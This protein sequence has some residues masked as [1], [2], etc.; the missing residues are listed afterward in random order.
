MA[1]TKKT[2]T[3]DNSKVPRKASRTAKAK[4]GPA[5]EETV[6][7]EA[8]L[9][10][11]EDETVPW[12]ESEAKRLLRQDL[13]E[14]RVPDNW[15]GVQVKQ[16]RP[17][18]APYSQAR[19]TAN[20][21]TLRDGLERD[22]AR[23]VEDV[24]IFGHDMALLTEY[25][26]KNPPR[27]KDYPNFHDHPARTLLKSDIDDNK[28]I[29]MKPMKLR[30]SRPE[31]Q[32]FPPNVFR[33]HI[34]Q[35]VDERLSRAYR[36]AKKGVR[37]KFRDTAHTKQYLESLENPAPAETTTTAAATAADLFPAAEFFPNA[38]PKR[39]AKKKSNN[40]Q[41]QIPMRQSES[42]KYYLPQATGEGSFLEE[43]RKLRIESLMA[44]KNTTRKK[45]WRS[46]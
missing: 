32:E 14:G 26:K 34:Y 33:K 41:E 19:F 40:A 13:I 22:Y 3:K 18:Y 12:A 36:F 35:E 39:R 25:H 21:K 28:H 29:E 27:E 8:V 9:E 7:E 1:R 11:E 38:P 15:T 37:A 4:K 30:E 6:E 2:G 5:E 16:M 17:E 20:L 10:D 24:E 43:Y 31:Y 23:M 44:S 42:P 46:S 45:K